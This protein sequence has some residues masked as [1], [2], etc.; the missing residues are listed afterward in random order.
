MIKLYSFIQEMA[1]FIYT[2][3]KKDSGTNYVLQI[4]Y[5]LTLKTRLGN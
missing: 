2:T 1:V 3:A 4:N 5:R